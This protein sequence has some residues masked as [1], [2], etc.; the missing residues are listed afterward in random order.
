MKKVYLEP[1][2]F[3]GNPRIAIRFHYD[4]SLIEKVRLIPGRLWSP[5]DKVWHIP[6]NKDKLRALVEYLYADDIFIDDSAFHEREK[7]SSYGLRSNGSCRKLSEDQIHQIEAFRMW[8]K[9]KRYSERTCDTY[10]GLIKSFLLF[11]SDISVREIT[12]N[13]II[14]FNHQF[15]L[16]NGYSIS[17]Q[18]QMVSA[19]KLFY[20]EVKHRRLDLDRLERP[21][22]EKK[23][24]VVFSMEEVGRI[25]RS[26][27]NEKHRI[28][29]SLIYSAGL[30]ISELLNLMPVDIDSTRMIIHIRSGKGRK[31]RIVPLSEKVFGSL[32]VYFRR[33]KPQVYLF[34]GLPG[35]RYSASS[36][37]KVL[38][39]AMERVGIKKQA[40]LHTL[41]HSYATHLLESG[42]D[43]RY[44]QV[45]LGHESSRT[46]EI[47]TH[48]GRNRIEVIKSPFDD[49]GI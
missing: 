9:G 30:R 15:I 13:D 47:Y 11:F 5:D 25:I 35:K 40:S 32:R 39:S 34:E 19:I 31:D 24:P 16:M 10:I 46:T 1:F 49:L 18:R 21:R 22:K 37:R 7:M 29:I 41:R 28:M 44:I 26:I 42:T 27:R 12:N 2:Q 4:K 20:K 38:K 17:Y 23:L 14:H 33:Y 8:L 43:I 45:L 48:V 3:G 6:F 36:C